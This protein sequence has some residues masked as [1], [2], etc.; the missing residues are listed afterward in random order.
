MAG[1]I[2]AVIAVTFG[3]LP[4]YAWYLGLPFERAG[5]LLGVWVLCVAALGWYWLSSPQGRLRWDGEVW[6]WSG[7][8]APL[9]RVRIQYDFQ[10]SM[11]ILLEPE[12]GRRFGL[13]VDADPARL[14][15]WQVLRRALVGGDSLSRPDMDS[16]DGSIPPVR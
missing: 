9:K 1:W 6:H 8:V 7:L 15:Q 4:F 12:Q 13:W 5:L 3:I 14:S 11:W 2:L 16:T 10:W